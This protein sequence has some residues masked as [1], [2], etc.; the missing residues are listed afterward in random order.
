M[1]KT[2]LALCLAAATLCVSGTAMAGDGTNLIKM[3]SA[4]SKIVMVFDVADARDS[5]LLQKG[6]STLLASKPEA[7]AKLDE[8]GMDP[9]RDIDT[10]LMAGS[11]K[12]DDFD[13]MSS[14]V[15]IVE[16]R[17][18]KEKF[19][20]VPGMKATKYGGTTIWSK[21]DGEVAM[22]GDRL[23]FTEA[24]KMKAAIDIAQGKGKGK[25]ANASVSKKAAGLRAALAATD[26]T[27]D[28]WMTV[29]LPDS[30]KAQMKEQGL[31]ADSVAA[32][33]NFTADLGIGI[34]LMTDSDASAGKVV[35]MAQAGMAA[36]SQ[37]AGQ[38]GFGKAAKSL[39]VTQDKAMVKV[40]LTVTEAELQT[41]MGLAG[42]ATPP[43]PPPATGK[44]PAKSTTGS[45]GAT[46][47]AGSLAPP[48]AKPKAKTP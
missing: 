14:M 26:T 7:K 6:Y 22:L 11:P 36:V 31:S 29:L 24:G 43:P 39:T 12:G 16:G 40:G 30:A 17:I 9:M 35:T 37:Q 15:V 28:M 21:D 41:L 45:T 8:L 4:D 34:R 3:I 27:A 2:R 18:P 47:P 10:V 38:M 5:T 19:A 1:V 32:G 46:P 23:L 44:P 25:G 33:V 48:P 13:D 42:V 20:T